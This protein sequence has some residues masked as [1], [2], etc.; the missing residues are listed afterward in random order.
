MIKLLLLRI[1]GALAVMS[2]AVVFV[3]LAPFL[4]GASGMS[5][6]YAPRQSAPSVNRQFKGDRL[7]IHTAASSILQN[8]FAALARTGMRSRSEAPSSPRIPFACD[9][10]FSPVASPRLAYVYGRCLS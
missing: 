4:G 9:P 1:A 8:D 3:G 5:V 7:P 6:S 10:S 2:L